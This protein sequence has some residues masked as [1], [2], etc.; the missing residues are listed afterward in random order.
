MRAT[1]ADVP[2]ASE[3]GPGS[4]PLLPSLPESALPPASPESSVRR[5]V[6]ALEEDIVFG[7]LH[8]R[9]R[10][11]EDGLR[12]RFGLK[13]HVVRQV[14][15]EL[16]QMGLVQR[17]KNIG[18]FVTSYTIKEVNDLYVVRE[19]LETS[20]ARHIGMPVPAQA[21]DQ[22]TAIQT[23]HDAAVVE[24]NLRDAFRSNIAFHKALFALTGN[25]SLTSA[26]ED[27]AQRTHIVRFLSMTVP[28]LLQKARSDHWRIIEALRNQDSELLVD[29]CKNH[30]RPSRDAYISQ[31]RQ[32][33]GY[34]Q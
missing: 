8:P 14:L 16:E 1:K 17:K 11:T 24:S 27:F 23:R 18:A 13:R 15:V 34:R 25:G 4:G 33:E 10:L 32:R 21:L 20:A 28:P 2:D 7:Y 6:E 5:T 22:L 26:I 31:Y 29:I 3:P 9:E 30:L 19:I 12:S